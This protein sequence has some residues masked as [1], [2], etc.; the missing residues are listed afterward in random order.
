MSFVLISHLL[1]VVLQ[2]TILRV[3][4]APANDGPALPPQVSFAFPSHPKNARTYISSH[5]RY[6]NLR[7]FSHMQHRLLDW[8]KSHLQL[9]MCG[10]SHYEILLGG[11]PTSSRRLPF[12][13]TR[14]DHTMTSTCIP[15]TL[16]REG[17]NTHICWELMRRHIATQTWHTTNIFNR[18]VKCLQYSAIATWVG[19]DR[20]R[21]KPDN[22]LIYHQVEVAMALEMVSMSERQGLQQSPTRGLKPRHPSKRCLWTDLQPGCIQ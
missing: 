22:W 4:A 21:D 11:A 17:N 12:E 20:R 18:G 13:I 16:N 1:W 19:L 2:F 6:H 5:V 15:M 3:R 9:A 8:L 10:S 14:H 7:M